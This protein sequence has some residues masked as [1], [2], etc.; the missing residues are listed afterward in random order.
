MVD[1]KGLLNWSLKYNDGTRSNEDIKPMSKE[2]MEFLQ[3]AFES[4]C[5]NEMQEIL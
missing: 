2:D 3:N 4:V 5:V 1:W